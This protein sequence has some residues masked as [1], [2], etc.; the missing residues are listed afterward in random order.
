MM[1][2]VLQQINPPD[3][4]FNVAYPKNNGNPTTED[5][6]ALF[7]KNGLNVKETVYP[8]ERSMQLRGI[9]RNRQLA[10][11]KADWVLWSDSDMVYDPLFFNDIQNKLAL[12]EY[13]QVTKCF[14]A[15][16]RSLEKEY[17]KDYFNKEDKHIYPCVIENVAEFVSKWPLRKKT[18]PNGAGYFQLANIENIRKN[19][20]GL[21]VIPENCID[22]P[23]VD[24]FQKAKSDR[25]F[26]RMLGGFHVMKTKPQYHLNHERDSEVGAHITIQR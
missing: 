7:K 19:H 25:Q 21:Y 2:S 12:P 15:S 18:F 13:N 26:R 1:S 4:V 14:S 20:G 6:C 3:I 9:V 8:D 24:R 17:C 11:S 16:R 5:V 22:F 10:E 23:T